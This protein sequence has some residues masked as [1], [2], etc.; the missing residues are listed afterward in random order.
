[1]IK[2]V[3]GRYAVQSGVFHRRFGRTDLILK[4]VVWRDLPV[5]GCVLQRDLVSWGSHSTAMNSYIFCDIT[6]CTAVK[7]QWHFGGKYR[8]HRQCRSSSQARNQNK[9]MRKL[10]LLLCLAYSSVIKMRIVCKLQNG[11]TASHSKKKT[12]F[13]R[14]FLLKR[15]P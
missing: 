6:P 1:M 7:V 11:Y 9:V 5:W 4:K 12:V 2:D 10:P 8:L 15:F 13:I 3:F 14:A